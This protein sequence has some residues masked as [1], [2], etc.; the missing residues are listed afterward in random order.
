M[1]FI[2]E[3]CSLKEMYVFVSFYWLSVLFSSSLSLPFNPLTCRQAGMIRAGQ[4]EF[5]IE[6][7]E[8]GGDMTEEEEGGPGRHHIVYRSSDIKRPPVNQ[9]ADFHPKGQIR[10]AFLFM[11]SQWHACWWPGGDVEEVDWWYVCRK[12]VY[13]A[14]LSCPLHILT[15]ACEIQYLARVLKRCVKHIKF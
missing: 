4:E 5:F 6:P 13:P 9:P 8:R 11:T 1:D 7:L 12:Y 2:C 3:L 10:S 15:N 14:V